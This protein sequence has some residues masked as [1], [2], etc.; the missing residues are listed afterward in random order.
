MTINTDF[1][2]S[3]SKKPVETESSNIY[4]LLIHLSAVH[5]T[6]FNLYSRGNNFAAKHT[7]I[8]LVNIHRY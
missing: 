1:L 3:Q 2:I 6:V 8:L 7:Y 5:V 4:I